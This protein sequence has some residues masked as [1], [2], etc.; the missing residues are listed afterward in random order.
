MSRVTMTRHGVAPAF[1]GAREAEDLQM[2]RQALLSCVALGALATSAVAADLPTHKGPPPAP[3]MV[4]PPFSWTG[5]YLGLNAGYADPS[6]KIGV[7]PGGAWIGDADVAG[8]TAAGTGKLNL[9]G[10]TGGVEAGYNYQINN[11]VLGVEG[12]VDYLDLRGSYATPTYDG[13]V[14]GTYWASGKTTVDTLFT[15]RGRAGLAADH[16]LFFVTGGLALADE[17]FSQ[18]IGFNNPGVVVT[19]PL[20]GGVNG[21]NAGSASTTAATWTI[22]GGVEY[23]FDRHWSFKGEYLYVDLKSLSFN[24]SYT[25]VTPETYTMTHHDSLSGLNI[26]RV[27]LNYRF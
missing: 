10:F 14:S 6:S 19:L 2:L 3:T 15:L 18:S 8:V 22:G 21:Y 1:L 20:T 27:G 23:A 24:S 11:I 5:F 17:K 4:A 7:I 16:W 26:F 25:S 9:D 12:D 13:A